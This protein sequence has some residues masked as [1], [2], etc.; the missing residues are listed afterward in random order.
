MLVASKNTL[1]N[2]T[3]LLDIQEECNSHLE[4]YLVFSESFLESMM[5]LH[6][7]I[8]DAVLFSTSVS[9]QTK[10]FC[11]SYT[12]FNLIIHFLYKKYIFTRKKLP[13]SKCKVRGSLIVFNHNEVET[14][15]LTL[16][17]I[18]TQ[19]FK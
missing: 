18:Q 7:I 8:Y 2:P 16:T 15:L 1:D 9:F 5:D 6:Q 10:H 11:S 17:V 3:N 14:M 13:H 12:A 4:Q 19:N